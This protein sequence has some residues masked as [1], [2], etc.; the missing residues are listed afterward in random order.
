MVL[1]CQIVKLYYRSI[2][3]LHSGD[4]TRSTSPQASPDAPSQYIATMNAVFAA[5]RQGVVMDSLMVGPYDS[6]LMQQGAFLTKGLYL[7]PDSPVA[8]L[9]HLLVRVLRVIWWALA[10]QYLVVIDV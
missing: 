4:P 9:Q 3:R 10:V 1:A 7:R 5:E 2:V 8:L 6:P